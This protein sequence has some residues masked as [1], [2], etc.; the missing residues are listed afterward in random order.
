MV[1]PFITDMGE[2]LELTDTKTGEKM[3]LDQYA[4]W[5]DMGKGKPE[6]K[7]KS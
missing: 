3:V 4:Y 7:I 1:V 5:C 6:V 2:K